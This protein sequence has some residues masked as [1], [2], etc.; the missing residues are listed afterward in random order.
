MMAYLLTSILLGCFGIGTFICMFVICFPIQLFLHIY[1][2]NAINNDSFSGI[3][4]F[5]DKIEYNIFEVKKLLVQINIHIG[6]MSTLYVF[7]LCV[8]NCMDLNIGWINGFLIALYV[9]NFVLTVI[10]HNYKV[11][12]KIYRNDEDKK[13]AIRSL[14]V[15]TIYIVLLFVGIMMIAAI[16]EMKGIENNTA[17]AMKLCGLLILGVL[18]ATSG[19]F[20]EDNQIKKWN[21]T[22]TEYKTN[23]ISIVSMSLC[24]MVYG[25]MFIV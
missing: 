21:P 18:I 22:E 16:F 9:L 2:S 11:I 19:F 4:G 15:T 6:M 5:N 8:I 17:P 1:F 7:L 12:D 25:L 24:M 3:A 23:K 10:I 14:P 13:R 20:I